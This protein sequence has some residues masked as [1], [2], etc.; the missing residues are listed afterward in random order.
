MHVAC[1][2]CSH[3]G[4]GH[5]DEEERAGEQACAQGEGAAGWVKIKHLNEKIHGVDSRVM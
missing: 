4:R 5:P 3:D 1:V 2:L